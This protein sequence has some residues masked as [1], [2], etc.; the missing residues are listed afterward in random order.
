[1]LR[2]GLGDSGV[3]NCVAEGALRSLK[4]QQHSTVS[5]NGFVFLS[6]P[7]GGLESRRGV[8]LDEVREWYAN[9]GRIAMSKKLSLCHPP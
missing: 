7:A 3:D 8:P 9:P 1:M 6:G 2:A 5:R 4:T